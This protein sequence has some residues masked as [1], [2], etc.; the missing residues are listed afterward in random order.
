MDDKINDAGFFTLFLR[1][2]L[3][4]LLARGRGGLKC[5]TAQITEYTTFPFSKLCVFDHCK[6]AK[7]SKKSLFAKSFRL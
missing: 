2:F 3:L 6:Q 7:E 4:P 1:P 5:F